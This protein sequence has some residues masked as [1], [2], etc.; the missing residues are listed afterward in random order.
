MST[1]HF[2]QVPPD[3]ALADPLPA[4]PL[5]LL[6]RWLSEAE[7]RSGQKNPLAMTVASVDEHCRPSAR[8]VLCR[9]FDA[10]AGYVVFY[11]NRNSRKGAELR[12][13]AHA[14]AVLHWDALERQVRIEGPVLYSPAAESDAYFARRPRLAQIS[15]WASQQSEPI[16]SRA[17]LL[18]QHASYGERY[19][20]EDGEPIPRPAHWGG[21][22]LYIE[23]LELWVGSAGRCH[24]RGLWTRRLEPEE[25]S[26]AGGAWQ[27][28]RLQP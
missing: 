10:E 2:E 7:A 17:E 4:E 13:H 26:Y 28:A 19:G 25:E 20:V 22:R 8:V 9:G 24:D 1:E 6:G 12:P 3:P 15:A 21:Y 27:V 11:S 14:A 23:R 18:A 5:A 16:G